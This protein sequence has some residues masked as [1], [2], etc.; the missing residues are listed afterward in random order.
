MKNLSLTVK[1]IPNAP[2]TEIVCLMDDGVLKI[3]VRGAP[4]K[5]KANQELIDFLADRFHVQKVD[6][7]LIS[8]TTSR[9]KKVIIAGRSDDDLQRLINPS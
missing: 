2:K 9:L 3:R 5:G 7:R 1:V 6:I 4:E 8:G